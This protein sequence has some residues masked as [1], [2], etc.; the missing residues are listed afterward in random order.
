MQPWSFLPHCSSWSAARYRRHAC[1]R[2]DSKCRHRRITL[3]TVTQAHA[4]HSHAIVGVG[5]QPAAAKTYLDRPERDVI[6]YIGIVLVEPSSSTM[7]PI[8]R[9]ILP[10]VFFG[11]ARTYDANPNPVLPTHGPPA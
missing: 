7:Y 11:G 6:V 3:C 4:H 2:S 10:L 1:I 8:Y 5:A 9:W